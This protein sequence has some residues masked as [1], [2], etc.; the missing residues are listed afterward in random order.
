MLMK[1]WQDAVVSALGVWTITQSWLADHLQAIV[2]WNATIVGFFIAAASL[3]ALLRGAAWKEWT[4]ALLAVWLAMSPW[5]LGFSAPAGLVWS[6]MVSGTVMEALALW[7]L[8][9]DR[10]L[11][12]WNV[13]SRDVI[14]TRTSPRAS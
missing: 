5:S 7:V 2:I 11:G 14:E 10:D 8:V 4:C 12:G 1:H 9:S 3:S 6:T 13:A